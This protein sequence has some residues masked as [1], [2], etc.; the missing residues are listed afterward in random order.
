MQNRFIIIIIALLVFSGVTYA[1]YPKTISIRN[2]PARGNKILAFGDSLTQGVGSDTGGYVRMLSERI[3]LPIINKGISGDTTALALSRINDARAEKPDIV[4][5]FLGGNDALRRVSVDETFRN[6]KTI[7]KDFQS[8]GAVILLVG[9]QGGIIGDKYRSPFKSLAKEMGTAF[10]P[11]ILN[12][13][14]GNAKLMSD[15]GI[16]PNDAGYTIITDRIAS[17]LIP[18]LPTSKS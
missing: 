13:I 8:D 4:I 1:L 17:V 2:A 14:F 16:H 15:D 7:I 3:K 6:L 18:L 10:D 11:D 9:V 12:G 5:L